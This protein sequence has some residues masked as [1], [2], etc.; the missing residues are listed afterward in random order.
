MAEIR[1]LHGTTVVEILNDCMER[2]DEIEAIALT[3]LWKDGE[4][5][6]GHSSTNP[7]DLALMVLALDTHQ[8]RVFEDRD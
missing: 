7:A 3:V 2:R 6:A 1:S 8:R 5:N 4:V